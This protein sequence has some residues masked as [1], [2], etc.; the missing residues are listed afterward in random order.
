M[1]K[2]DHARATTNGGVGLGS[3]YDNANVSAAASPSAAEITRIAK[4]VGI[5]GGSAVNY[6]TWAAPNASARINE[7]LRA[8]KG[9]GLAVGSQAGPA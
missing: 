3:D 9:C 2:G 7:D 5:G 1:A 4:G 6:T 8:G